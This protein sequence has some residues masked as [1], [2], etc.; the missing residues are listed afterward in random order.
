MAAIQTLPQHR[1]RCNFTSIVPRHGVVTL[2]GYGIRVQVQRGHL[3]LEDGI[4]ADRRH[5][6]IPRVGHGLKR[7]VIIGSDGIVSLA[8]IRWLADQNVSLVMLERNG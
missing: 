7:L 1:Y 3:L 2:S 8:A 4:A 6:R 5:A